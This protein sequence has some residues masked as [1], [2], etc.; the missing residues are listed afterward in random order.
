MKKEKKLREKPNWS[1]PDTTA[2]NE[3]LPRWL[4]WVWT[5]RGI[6]FSL[7]VVL[8][9]HL[10]YYCTDLLGM[11]PAL[12]GS[13]LLASK[14]FDGF[15][16]LIA[17]FIID[18]TRTKWGKARP[19]DIFIPLMWLFTV[20]LFTVPNF[21]TVG[22]CVYIF[23]MYAIVNSVCS[24]FVMAADPV[25]LGRTIRND[26][27]KMSLTS[28]QGAFI[29]IA[30][31]A[32]SIIIPQLISFIGTEKSG[33]TIIALLF[34]VP[35]TIVGSLRML[36]V[37]ELASVDELNRQIGGKLS[38]KESLKALAKNKMVFIL[39]ILVILTQTNVAVTQAVTNYYF[40]WIFGDVG[41]ASLVG[42]ANVA[43][44]IVLA[45][46]PALSRKIGTGKL[47]RFGLLLTAI[48]YGI[49]LLAGAN[50][51]AI[52]GGTL[53]TTAGAVPI[54]VLLSIYTLECMDY[55][56]WKNGVR[57]EGVISSVMGFSQ[58]VG[59]GVGSAILGFLMG[60]SG[61]IS[62]EAATVQPDSALNMIRFLFNGLPTLLA[63]G[64]FVL[65]LFYTI[66]KVSGKMHEALSQK[67]TAEL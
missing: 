55:G 22:K 36:M 41:L 11:A 21:G 46:V 6:A 12:V 9:M 14:V 64:C 3:R 26:K 44:P 13:L 25:F 38:L 29:M 49:R 1:N 23:I 54:T 24:T 7:N 65:S 31:I 67:N 47:L 57:V 42:A 37:K 27:N 33:W 16:D 52:M 8:L 34:A 18:K 28:F 61:Y 50:I 58:K 59:S 43:T 51:P 62:S 45:F 32:A 63:A 56:E 40:K 39:G 2:E 20:L 60:M 5:G 53:L 17:G 19:Y 48:G 10:T 35:L 15:T 30:S 4:K 66:D